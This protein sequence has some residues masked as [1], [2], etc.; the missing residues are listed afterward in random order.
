MSDL[1]S[2]ERICDRG[3]QEERYALLERAAN[4]AKTVWEKRIIRWGL[5]ALKAQCKRD[6]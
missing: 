5:G 3:T 2:E 6:W 1:G 4:E